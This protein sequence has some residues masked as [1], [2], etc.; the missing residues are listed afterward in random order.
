MAFDDLTWS[1]SEFQRVGTANEQANNVIQRS[2][3]I[4]DG[5]FIYTR[6]KC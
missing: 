4:S 6:S 5:R 3:H 2:D 1:G